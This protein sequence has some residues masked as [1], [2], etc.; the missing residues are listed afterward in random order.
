[1]GLKI[2]SP[3]LYQLSYQPARA[4]SHPTGPCVPLVYLIGALKGKKTAGEVRS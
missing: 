3:Q 1:M 2:K 4:E